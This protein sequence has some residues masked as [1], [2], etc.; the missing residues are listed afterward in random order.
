MKIEFLEAAEIR[1]VPKRSL[2]TSANLKKFVTYDEWMS[3]V[4]A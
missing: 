2:G 1:L 4:L 3:A